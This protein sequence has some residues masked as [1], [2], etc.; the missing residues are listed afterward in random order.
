M[1]GTVSGD[2]ISSAS[3]GDCGGAPLYLHLVHK[4]LNIQLLYLVSGDKIASQGDCGGAPGQPCLRG[5]AQLEGS[6][7]KTSHSRK[8]PLHTFR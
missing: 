2:K 1:P 8:K 5:G 7:P 3:Q 4:M 6:T